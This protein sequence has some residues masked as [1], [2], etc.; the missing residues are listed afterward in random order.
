MLEKMQTA[1]NITVIGGGFIG[2]E[3]A[4]Q[5]CHLGKN[6]TLVEMADACLW[7]AF[8]KKYTDEIEAALKENGIRVLTSTKVS[9]ILGDKA[10]TAVELENG[11][12]R[13]LRIS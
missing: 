4:E 11:V 9:K 12:K 10:V 5:I 7:Q 2:A 1:E 6:V 3:F 13:S 8:D